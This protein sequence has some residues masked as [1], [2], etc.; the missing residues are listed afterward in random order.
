M[1][2][3]ESLRSHRSK[4]TGSLLHR[5]VGSVGASFGNPLNSGF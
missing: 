2:G 4:T 1:T 5:D 3:Q